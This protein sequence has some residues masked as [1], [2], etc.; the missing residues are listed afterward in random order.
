[1]TTTA[2]CM[3]A[4]L[5]SAC[6]VLLLAGSLCPAAEQGETSL[7]RL[8]LDAP[9][10][11]DVAKCIRESGRPDSFVETRY[12]DD[13]PMPAVR[14]EEERRGYLVFERHWMDLVFPNS[15]PRRGEITG[16]LSVFAARGEYEPVTFC[17]RTLRDISGLEVK[18]GALVSQSGERLAGPE[19][20]IV[21]CAPRLWR[22]GGPLYEDGPVG[23]MN[24]PMYLEEAGAA[25][26]AAERTVQYWLTVKVGADAAAGVY[27]GEIGI[28]CEGTEAHTLDLAVE[29]L[30]IT[31]LEP[32]ITLGFWDF[33]YQNYR[34]D[35]GSVDEVYRVMRRHG[36]NA[37]FMMAGLFH[38]HPETDTHDFSRHLSVDETGRAV[39]TWE[40]SPLAERMAAAKE[41][42][43][44]TVCYYPTFGGV[45][46][47]AVQARVDKETLDQ[48]ISRELDKVLARHKGSKHYDLIQKETTNVSEK[49][50]PM[51]SEAYA[52]LYVQVLQDILKE[53]A[54]RRWP[55]I[56]MDPGDET[57]SHHVHDR[58]AFPRVI[59][60]LEL[61]K[62]AGATTLL[63]HV[64]P[65]MGGEYGEYVREALRYVDI[66]M[67]GV[68]LSPSFTAPYG[69]TME[70]MVQGFAE[71]GI[72]TYTYNMTMPRMPDLEGAR[73][74]SGYFFD[75][76]GKG[77]QGELD[78]VFF[79]VE[80]NPYNPLD[81][82]Y[83]EHEFL[84]YLPP[85]EEQDRLGGPALSLAAKREGVDDQRYLHTLNE[86]IKRAEG[87]ADS[88]AVQRAA[89]AAAATRKRILESFDFS[90]IIEKGYTR[91][92]W[93]TVV[94][95]EGVQPT[96]K[97]AY[98]LPNGWGFETY[99]R[100]RRKIAQAIIKL[101]AALA[102]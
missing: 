91:S 17:V 65:M 24:M 76:L 64:S 29:V 45:L 33:A 19:V 28:S 49:Y 40:G 15:I 85:R 72:T 7:G 44:K 11:S 18:A 93:D 89:R 102:Q 10:K 47:K 25:D 63:N 23:V 43:F 98:R 80:G 90:H 14:P 2:G 53:A 69:G 16:K 42:G 27:S 30:P 38:Y 37:L 21:R 32:E 94:V 48:E 75:T 35:I 1:M 31:L 51:F 71:L 82:R 84:W 9:E 58:V 86:L 55:K 101:Q 67:P 88:P 95:R 59:R 77:V 41:A 96:V 52:T 70:K 46:G 36:M 6:G 100:N 8:L 22:G 78:Y 60:H 3:K 34:G 66:G 68:R 39:I 73:F 57:F 87:K 92:R 99:D 62:R 83:W 26:V 56:I 79:R 13:T 97:G 50:Y 61:M 4:K 81:K 12:I 74:D 5:L 20:R 54:R